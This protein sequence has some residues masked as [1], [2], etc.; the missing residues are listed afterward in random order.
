[1]KLRRVHPKREGGII[2]RES[3]G[4]QLKD[5]IGLGDDDDNAIAARRLHSINQSLSYMLE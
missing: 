5:L 2:K 4:I 1:M 3:A